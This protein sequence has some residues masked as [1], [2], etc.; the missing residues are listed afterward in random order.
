MS[1]ETLR[2]GILA[3]LQPALDTHVQMMTDR[4]AGLEKSLLKDIGYITK[5]SESNQKQLT[6]LKISLADK[7]VDKAEL[8]NT[9]AVLNSENDRKLNELRSRY[10]PIRSVLLWAVA[11]IGGVILV[12]ATA[13]ILNNAA[14]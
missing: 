9:I 11:T 12:G 8:L 10:E 5:M 7:Y 1:E 2:K 6:N 13:F 14:F 4:I 3:G